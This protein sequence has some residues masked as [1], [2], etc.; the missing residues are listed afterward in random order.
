MA[1]ST[2]AHAGRLPYYTFGYSVN[3][4]RKP[5]LVEP[6]SDEFPFATDT[7]ST[8]SCGTGKWTGIPPPA[9]AA[10][11]AVD[12]RR[13]AAA[14][15]SS[16]SSFLATHATTPLP[17]GVL[18]YTHISKT[19]GET[20]RHH[21]RT[22]TRKYGWNFLDLYTSSS[23]R[24]LRRAGRWEIERHVHLLAQHLNRSRPRLVVHQHDGV[25]G[26]GDYFLERV[27]R[28]LSCRL[29]VEVPECKVVLATV[30][31]DP[32]ARLISQAQ[33]D[34]LPPEQFSA[35]A[36]AQANFQ[37]KYLLFTT[38]WRVSSLFLAKP[39]VEQ[40]LLE[41]AR[42][43]LSHAELV[44]R[45]EELQRFLVALDR[46]MGWTDESFASA[47]STLH[48]GHRS[49]KRWN[50]TAAQTVFARRFNAVDALLYRTFCQ[51]GDSP[52]TVVPL[53]SIGSTAAVRGLP[54]YY[55]DR[56]VSK[57]APSPSEWQMVFDGRACHGFHLGDEYGMQCANATHA[58]LGKTL[59]KVAGY[60]RERSGKLTPCVVN[61]EPTKSCTTGK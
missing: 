13:P 26:L 7:G 5:I 39:D 49:R 58:T 15:T 28:P 16:S 22:R 3:D 30:L 37:T 20:V 27:L 11:A 46:A 8:F 47:Q 36:R 1:S 6:P 9:A 31:R 2:G 38:D 24:S 44:G 52:R 21:L 18:W 51:Q 50:L 14:S 54:H 35:Y 10:A 59:G 25:G 55:A 61:G 12:E 23:P 57:H 33:S 29:Q 56:D 4:A 45:T 42:T 19:G 43:V 40:S 60:H 48:D 32:V 34:S 41:P 17:C 53:C